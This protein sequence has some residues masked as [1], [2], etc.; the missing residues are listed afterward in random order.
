MKAVIKKINKGNLKGQFRFVL[1]ADNGEP[2]AQSWAET[3]KTKQMVKKTLN[4]FFP[5]FEIIKK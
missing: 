1:V 5:N 2:I 4:K 3:Y